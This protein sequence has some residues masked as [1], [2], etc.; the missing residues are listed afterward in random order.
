MKRERNRAISEQPPMKF[1]MPKIPC[2]KRRLMSEQSQIDHPK[3]RLR[4]GF[5]LLEA[6]VAVVLLGSVMLTFL[7][8]AHTV[9]EQQ[10][11]T[12]QELVAL[13]EAENVLEQIAARPTL[14]RNAS[15][16]SKLKLS[17]PANSRLPNAEL[18]IEVSEP[19]GSPA[20]FRI[21]VVIRWSSH[22]AKKTRS[23]QLAAWFPVTEAK[24]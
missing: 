12:D 24:P 13:R 19:T 9:R 3:H 18:K 23:V 14:E 16:L 8:M 22:S 2:S 1:L 7:P 17:E 10:R 15:G 20:S 21:A 6:F 11:S 5:S 4:S